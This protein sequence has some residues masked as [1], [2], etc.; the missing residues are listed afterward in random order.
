MKKILAMLLALALFVVCVGCG[1][2][3]AGVQ[4]DVAA[5]AADLAGA[6]IFDDI[7]SEMPAQ[8]APKFYA[9]DEG[10]VIECALYQSTMAAA[11]EVFVAKCADADAA[12]RVLTACEGRVAEQTTAYESYV[13]AEIPKLESAILLAVGEYAIFVVSNN[14]AEAQSIVDS[15]L[16]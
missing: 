5:L 6:D 9:Y 12:K 7:V 2:D 4:I 10:D 8:L 13:P 1:S 15:Y 3:E 11:E 16:K 14:T